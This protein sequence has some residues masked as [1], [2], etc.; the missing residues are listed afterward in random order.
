[1]SLEGINLKRIEEINAGDVAWFSK[2]V[3]EADI[4]MFAQLSGDYAPQ[5][6]SAEFGKTMMYGSRIAHG[7]LTAGLICPVLNKL[8]GDG[9]VTWSQ[10]IKFK[11]AVLLNDTVTVRGEVT[12]VIPEENKVKIQVVCRKQ[13]TGPE[14]RPLI[15][16]EF[17][18]KIEILGPLA[19]EV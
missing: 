7:M 10:E 1:M 9:A 14:D 2:T 3:T 18:E 16:A 17:V 12:E 5:H 6:V 4:M 19:E 11:S 15:L 13:G 8:C